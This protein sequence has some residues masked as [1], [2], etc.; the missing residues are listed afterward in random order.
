MF[1]TPTA[2]TSSATAPSPRNRPLNAPW[3]SAR[4]VSV[5]EGWLTLTSL[6]ASGSR[7][8]GEHRLDGRD[9]A[10]LGA[11]VDGVG[12]PVELQ[13][14]FRGLEADEHRAFDF[15]CEHR[16]AE[17]PHEVEPLVDGPDPLTG[18]DVVDPESLRG[19]GA[20]HRGRLLGGGGVQ[21]AALHDVDAQRVQQAEARGLN[22]QSVGFDGGDQRR[23][24]DAAF[25]L[26]RLR[27]IF[28]RVDTGDHRGRDERQLGRLAG[29]AL[30]VGDGQEVRPQ[31]VDLCSSPAWLEEDRPS[32]A[33]IAATP[34]A[35]PSAESPARIRRVRKP[36][37]ATRARSEARSR[38]G[39]RSAAPALVS[40]A[41][42]RR[43]HR[44][45]QTA[46]ALRLRARTPPVLRA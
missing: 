21:V 26:P 39:A 5:A 40:G 10:V 33:T 13:V 23:A 35:I 17:D 42:P 19:R 43:A 24:V 6:G 41:S 27:D 15:G 14:A 28:D 20:E 7:G 44:A 16:W 30:A 2:P 46:R 45:A 29:E 8:R 32:T 38:R 37:L 18:V 1:A 36:T 11:Q 12:V 22:T 3:A 34:I 31:S 25:D 9:L 4:A